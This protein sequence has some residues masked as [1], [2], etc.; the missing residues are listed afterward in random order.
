MSGRRRVVRFDRHGREL[1]RGMRV[2]FCHLGRG[3]HRLRVQLRGDRWRA[4][5]FRSSI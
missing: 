2:R 1:R 3:R 5:A 4:V